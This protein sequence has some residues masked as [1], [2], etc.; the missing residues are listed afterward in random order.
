MANYQTMPDLSEEAYEGLKNSIKERGVEVAVIKDEFGDIIDGHHR[1][2]ACAELGITEYPVEVRAGLTPQQKRALSRELNIHRRHLNTKQK[3]EAI[4]EHLKDVPEM[5]DRAIAE[6]FG[7]DHK[8][9]SSVRSEISASGEIPHLAETTGKDGR[10]RKRQAKEG[11]QKTKHT[12]SRGTRSKV[13]DNLPDEP[14]RKKVDTGTKPKWE[15]R[16]KQWDGGIGRWVITIY[17]PELN[18]EGFVYL[19]RGEL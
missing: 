19:S 14:S 18:I 10:T 3:R 5:S 8:T 13:P 17:A 11:G 12:R 2:R 16:D 4:A 1:A 9:V 7:V 15:I 6:V